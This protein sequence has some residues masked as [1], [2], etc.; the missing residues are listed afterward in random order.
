MMDNTQKTE[1]AEAARGQRKTR[2]GKVVS[3]K[4]DK[5]VV[6]A[7]ERRKPGTPCDL[8][9]LPERR[10]LAGAAPVAQGP[11]PRV[12]GR[13][14]NQQRPGAVDRAV[15]DH[16][17]LVVDGDERR[18]DLVQE[19]GQVLRLVPGRDDDG[20]DGVWACHGRRWALGAAPAR[21]GVA[22]S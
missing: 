12:P 19:H 11:Y 4:M 21:S 7:I 20:D 3:N 22:V 1:T 9:R 14:G 18:R 8:G 16:Q 5:T 13:P 15:V 6:V 2:I 17:H 10:A